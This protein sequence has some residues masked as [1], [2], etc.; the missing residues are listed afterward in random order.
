M[1]KNEPTCRQ[2]G[3][4]VFLDHAEALTILVGAVGQ[5]GR[6]DYCSFACADEAI[7]QRDTEAA[8]IRRAV[9]ARRRSP[10]MK[11]EREIF[12]RSHRALGRAKN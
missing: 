4:P 6:L 11:T 3:E 2:C 7:C 10:A 9:H 1:P 8:A 12:A 5:H